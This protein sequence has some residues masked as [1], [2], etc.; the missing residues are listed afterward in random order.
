L[1]PWIK[2]TSIPCEASDCGRDGAVGFSYD[3]WGFVGLGNNPG[4][5]RELWRYDTENNSWEQMSDFPGVGRFN[6]TSF[7]INNFAYVGG[8]QSYS[9]NEALQDFY[10]YDLVNDVWSQIRDFPYP[11]SSATG[12]SNGEKGFVATTEVEENFWSYNP[13][14]DN[15]TEEADLDIASSDSK[16]DSGFA[17]NGQLYYYVYGIDR[18]NENNVSLVTELHRF[19]PF[20]TT[21]TR[22]ADLPVNSSGYGRS[23]GFSLNASGY[24]ISQNGRG[25]YRYDPNSDNW[26]R[27]NTAN[28]VLFRFVN[29]SVFTVDGKAYYGGGI[30]PSGADPNDGLWEYD[31]SYEDE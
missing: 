31:P 17:L 7:V 9:S 4:L 21:W 28:A 12:L 5:N 6:A 26:K 24:I 15:W 27:F 20:S 22:L 16:V 30:R 14:S 1:N 2:R 11:L 23:T 10:K 18:V 29:A 19:D 25:L 8:G 3:R 13:I